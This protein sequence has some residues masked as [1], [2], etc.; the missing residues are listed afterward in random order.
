MVNTSKWKSFNFDSKSVFV[1]NEA[2]VEE[3]IIGLVEGGADKLQVVSDFDMT[4]SRPYDKNGE[5]CH[6]CYQALDSNDRLPPSYGLKA[7][8]LKDFYYPI[9]IDPHLSI[10]DKIPLMVEWWEKAHD[11][12]LECKLHKDLIPKLVEESKVCFRDNTDWL[13]ER[14]HEAGV[15]LLVFSAGIGNVIS[16]AF[17]IKARLYDNIKIVSNFM[18]FD[19]E[20]YCNGFEGNLLHVFNK[21]ENVIHKSDYFEQIKHRHNL[22]LM[23]DSLGD[24]HM[25]DGACCHHVLKIGFLNHHKEKL[26]EKYINGYDIVICDD[27][28]LDVPNAIIDR[29]MNRKQASAKIEASQELTG[30]S[31]LNL[32]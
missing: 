30:D 23:G 17:K 6:S 15:P 12:M 2:Y 21:N 10:K 26:L 4:L 16:E 32:V 3:V 8:A 24:L 7:H 11:L 27:Q 19:A 28:S 25:A 14:L 18:T 22:V 31:L 29:V 5:A 13:L 1:K 9:E 20:G